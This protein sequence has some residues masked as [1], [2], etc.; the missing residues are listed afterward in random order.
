MRVPEEIIKEKL[1]NH[2]NWLIKD[3]LFP[4][5]IQQQEIDKQ[6]NEISIFEKKRN[7]KFRFKKQHNSNT[8]EIKIGD[9]VKKDKKLATVI[10]IDGDELCCQIGE[11]IV[12]WNKNE[13]RNTS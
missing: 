1:D 4:N 5:P 13:V 9:I 12:I 3:D 2:F 6:L 7:G 10:D 11:E 8:K